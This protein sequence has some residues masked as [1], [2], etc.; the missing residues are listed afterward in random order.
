MF[1][2]PE[3]RCT[4]TG[5][6]TASVGDKTNTSLPPLVP[7]FD[8]TIID[9]FLKKVDERISSV[10]AFSVMLLN[11]YAYRYYIFYVP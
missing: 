5:L 9:I 4:R 8:F 1:P 2:L 6:D 7:N 3:K 11:K 10:I